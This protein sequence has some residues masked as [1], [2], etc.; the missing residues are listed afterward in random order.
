MLTIGMVASRA[1]LRPSAIRYY[2]EQGLL[3]AACRKGGRRLYDVSILDRLALITLGKAAGFTLQEIRDLTARAGRRQPGSLWR[4]AADAKR[5]EVDEQIAQL[6]AR[7]SLLAQLA[8]C[9]CAT[10]EHCGRAFK[11]DQR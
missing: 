7:R 10:L 6:L 8:R 2:E 4:S 11:T 1:G 9:S 3:P 5:A